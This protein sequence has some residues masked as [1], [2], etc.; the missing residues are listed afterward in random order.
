[1]R[2]PSTI[3][4]GRPRLRFLVC[5]IAALAVLGAAGTAHASPPSDAGPFPLSTVPDCLTAAPDSGGPHVCKVRPAFGLADWQAGAGEWI[6]VR[7]GD[8]EPDQAGCLAVQAS[9]VATITVD[10]TTLPVDTTP[11]QFSAGSWVV[12]Y[13]ALSHP[14]AP[15][16]HAI[17]TSWY[18]TTAAVGNAAGSTLTFGTTLTVNPQG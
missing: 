10:G 4:R 12:D 2:Q 8:A 5:T 14:L 13:R 9:V 7:V 1:M 18:F 17:S 16:D 15:G 11:C 6:V 3:G